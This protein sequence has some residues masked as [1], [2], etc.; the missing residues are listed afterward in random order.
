MIRGQKFMEIIVI[1]VREARQI[2]MK[3]VSDTT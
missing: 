1:H 2:E 3:M